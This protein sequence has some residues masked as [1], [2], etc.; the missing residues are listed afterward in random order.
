MFHSFQN[1]IKWAFWGVGDGIP[2]VQQF[3]FDCAH[4]YRRLQS[5]LELGTATAHALTIARRQLVYLVRQ[6]VC[7]KLAGTHTRHFHLIRPNFGTT[8]LFAMATDTCYCYGQVMRERKVF[9]PVTRG[10]G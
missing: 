6:N 7:H 8:A 3:T 4:E 9:G 5:T 10:S 1:Q 2:I